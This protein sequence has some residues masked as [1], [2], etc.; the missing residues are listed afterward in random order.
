[1]TVMNALDRLFESNRDEQTDDDGD[2]VDEEVA[3]GVDGLVRCVNVE[4]GGGFL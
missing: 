1:M 4:D 2:D 3:P